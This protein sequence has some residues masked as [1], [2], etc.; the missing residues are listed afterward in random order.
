M[1]FLIYFICFSYLIWIFITKLLQ[2]ATIVSPHSR[3][4]QT[5]IKIIVISHKSKE[6]HESTTNSSTTDNSIISNERID[7]TDSTIAKTNERQVNSNNINKVNNKEMFTMVRTI[8]FLSCLALIT[9]LSDVVFNIIISFIYSKQK[10]ETI[11]INFSM[12]YQF[13][14][15]INIVCLL[16]QFE[17]NKKYYN[18]FC[19]FCDILMLACCNI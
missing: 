10:S 15:C 5:N 9:S 17:H 4:N 18:K 6:L 3:E 16:L 1:Q 7:K 2:L 8:T 11:L 12:F 19:H 14:Y 13:D